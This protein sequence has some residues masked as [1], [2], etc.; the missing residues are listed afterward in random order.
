[1]TSSQDNAA[2]A[3]ASELDAPT[4]WRYDYDQSAVYDANGLIVATFHGESPRREGRAALIVAA[5]N[6]RD[7]DKALIAEMRERER[8]YRETIQRLMDL[9]P[10]VTPSNKVGQFHEC[11]D[12]LI[13]CKC[14]IA[15]EWRRARALLA[16][17]KAIK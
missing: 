14:K 1:M 3:T 13:D 9:Q 8:Q 11:W 16:R 5:V 4:P 10:H 6:E 7:A 15:T 2:R 12:G 17:A